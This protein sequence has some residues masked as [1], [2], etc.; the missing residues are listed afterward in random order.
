MQKGTYALAGKRWACVSVW[1][2]IHRICRAYGCAGAPEFTIETDEQTIRRE[3][4]RL[5]AKW[6]KYGL[7]L[8]DRADGF[9][10]EI[11]IH[12]RLA[13]RLLEEDILF[14]HASCVAVDGQA[15]LFAARSGT[16]KSTHARYWRELFGDRAV[17]I[18]DDTPLL[19]VEQSGATAFGA[20]WSGKHGLNTNT[21][22]P[23]RAICLLERSGT[24][25]IEPVSPRD[26]FPVLYRQSYHLMDESE[27]RVLALADRL[28][29]T[30]R[31]YRLGADM[32]VEAARVAYEGMNGDRS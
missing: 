17:M 6:E 24:R 1:R 28:S 21:S 8:K 12:D 30:V 15:Y 18:N 3:R 20:P 7:S 4:P 5:E 26:A 2:D 23:V 11:I 32:S 31:V 25:F 19:R 29:R 22:A 9:V 27:R 14:F 13:A 16:G 10:E